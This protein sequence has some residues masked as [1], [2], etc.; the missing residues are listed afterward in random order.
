MRTVLGKCPHS[1]IIW[2]KCTVLSITQPRIIQFH[3][4]FVRSL[5]IGHPKCCKSSRSRGQRSRS[6]CDITYHHQKIVTSHKRIGYLSLSYVKII[7]Q[8]SLTREGHKV[9]HSNCNNSAVDSS[10]LLKFGTAFLQITDD[11]LHMFRVKGQSSR[12]QGQR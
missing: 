12:S 11:S 7:P 6:Q 3:S 8:H 4:N 9:K 5:N 2:W 1:E 10:I